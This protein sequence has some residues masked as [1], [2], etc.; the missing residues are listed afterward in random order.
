MLLHYTITAKC[1]LLITAY[2][3]WSYYRRIKH[4]HELPQLL[5]HLLLLLLPQL[6]LTIESVSKPNAGR[7]SRH[8]QISL[9]VKIRFGVSRNNR[10]QMRM[11]KHARRTQCCENVEDCQTIE[12]SEHIRG[13]LC[14][15]SH[16]LMC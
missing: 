1:I 8:V 7:M 15:G 16:K 5:L 11:T 2:S 3:I 10:Q 12:D 6:L 9:E 4:D 14:S 13:L